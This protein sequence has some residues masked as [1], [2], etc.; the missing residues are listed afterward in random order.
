MTI[1]I[2]SVLA[3]ATLLAVVGCKTMPNPDTKHL[4]AV[5]PSFAD[6]PISDALRCV[7]DNSSTLRLGVHMITDK[8][9]RY[10]PEAEGAPLPISG[11]E[12][13]ITALHKAGVRLVNRHQTSVIEWE[14]SF[15][16]KHILGDGATSSVEGTDISYRPIIKGGL[17][18]SDYFVTGAF[19]NL[20]WNLS[21]GGVEL[22]V[23]GAGAGFR[24][25]EMLIAA[26]FQVWD[27]VTSELYWSDTIAKRLTGE[28]VKIGLFDFISDDLVDF[29]AGF[30]TSNPTQW[31]SR[32]ITE[33]AAYNIAKTVHG[34]GDECD[35]LLPGRRIAAGEDTLTGRTR[36]LPAGNTLETVAPSE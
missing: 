23:A 15:A 21:S 2:K 7:G 22:E 4:S 11:T 12:M 25:F 28:E 14:L 17:R 31:T 3:T 19:N 16:K 6:T 30:Q 34:S 26:D 24:Q 13:M 36:T 5:F 32:Y 8:T 33:L 18:G 1:A 29:N 27:S 35:Q 10:T 9:N 20:D